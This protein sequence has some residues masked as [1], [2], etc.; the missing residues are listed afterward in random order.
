MSGPKRRP[1]ALPETSGER[2]GWGPEKWDR[3]SCRSNQARTEELPTPLKVGFTLRSRHLNPSRTSLCPRGSRHLRSCAVPAASFLFLDCDRLAAI[4]GTHTG[5][6]LKPP[7]P[8]D[9]LL[10]SL[11]ISGQGGLPDR[12]KNSHNCAHYPYNACHCL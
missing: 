9:R 1:E 8:Q 11:Q 3:L 10:L 4:S 2:G 7:P 6:S 5:R 12:S